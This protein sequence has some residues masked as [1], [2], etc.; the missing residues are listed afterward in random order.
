MAEHAEEEEY[1]EAPA[2]QQVVLVHHHKHLNGPPLF[3]FRISHHSTS[4]LVPF[5]GFLASVAWC[6]CLASVYWQHYMWRVLGFTV[7]TEFGLIEFDFDM[8]HLFAWLHGL[9]LT[10]RVGA[11]LGSMFVKDVPNIAAITKT[12]MPAINEIEKLSGRNSLMYFGDNCENIFQIMKNSADN[13]VAQHGN[14]KV[15]GDV[16][17]KVGDVVGRIEQFMD[18][19]GCKY[20]QIA[21]VW[22]AYVCVAVVIITMLFL[23]GCYDVY[24]QKPRARVLMQMAPSTFVNITFV[25]LAD[26]IT[27]WDKIA[28]IF[29]LLM[30]VTGGRITKELRVP[31]IAMIV[32]GCISPAFIILFVMTLYWYRPHP[33]HL[34]HMYYQQ[35]AN[36]RLAEEAKQQRDLAMQKGAMQKGKGKGHDAGEEEEEYYEEAK[37]GKSA[38]KGRGTRG[39]QARQGKGKA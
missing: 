5:F 16:L 13:V 7:F 11:G 39:G 12:F 26:K 36:T 34:H 19:K 31:G 35:L 8:Y 30:N 6:L 27:A 20:V 10:G 23:H 38:G 29:G 9:I 15:V 18:D 4:T 33:E 32:A 17:F 22:M 28:N 24:E 1:A 25:A 3:G 14:D 37:P 2:T 21:N